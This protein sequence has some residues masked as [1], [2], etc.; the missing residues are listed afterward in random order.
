[1]DACQHAYIVAKCELHA[2]PSAALAQIA[3]LFDAHV[4]IA[5]GDT[6]VDCKSVLELLQLQGEL[7]SAYTVTA[8]GPDAA[9]VVQALTEALQC[10]DGSSMWAVLKRLRAQKPP[11]P[12][13]I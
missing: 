12:P 9:A 5:K 3:R 10:P 4:T 1:M 11:L 13:S 7:G 8:S 6:I 2:T